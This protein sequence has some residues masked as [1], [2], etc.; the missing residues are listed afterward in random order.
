MTDTILSAD[1]ADFSPS[2]DKLV[3]PNERRLGLLT[4][5]LGLLVWAALIL[6]TF[7]LALIY[8]LLGGLVYLFAQSGLVAYLRGHGARL[9]AQQYPELYGQFQA[10]CRRLGLKDEPEA[11][12]LH[13]DG[14]MNAFAA[15]FLG[16]HYVVL[17]SA[18]V[19]A[20]DK[21]PD[22][23]RFYMGHELGHIKRG[24]LTGHLWRLPVLWLPLLGAAYSRAQ[25]TTCDLH[26]LACCSSREGGA[27]A[28]AALVV[29]PER[30]ATL[31]LPALAEQLRYTRGFWMSFHELTQGYPWLTKRIARLEARRVPGRHPLAWLLALF[32]P[33]GG[34]AA[35][36]LGPLV[37]VAIVGILAAV[38]LP[39]YQDYT[40]RAKISQAL[41]EAHT[42]QRALEQ[43]YSQSG[44]VPASLDALGLASTLPG[45]A[46]IELAPK[47]MVL[48]LNLGKLGVHLVP[49]QQEGGTFQWHCQAAEGTP[50]RVLPPAC[51]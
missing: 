25:E 14:W 37:A 21:H 16:R 33:Y 2:E 36:A 41:Q 6:G 3:A 17:L 50:T 15:R 19:D 8:L 47:N 24:H 31:N 22:G 39:A 10:C 46:H 42:V 38:A 34:R 12:V 28:L 4:L 32:T 13:G 44:E 7:G 23:V 43:H 48:R 27:R 1:P 5:V 18:V 20:M 49:Q 26:G 35:G 29:G 9:S 30:W 45:G 40:Q 11:Y 51:R